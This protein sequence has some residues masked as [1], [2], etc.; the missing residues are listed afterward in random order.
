[1]YSYINVDLIVNIINSTIIFFFLALVNTLRPKFDLMPL[2]GKKVWTSNNKKWYG[3]QI[4]T[5]EYIIVVSMMY[6]TK[7]LP[8]CFFQHLIT[9][10][11][12]VN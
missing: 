7:S 5:L 10:I 1:M 9:A 11:S 6:L 8:F 12:C 2:F 3:V 4:V